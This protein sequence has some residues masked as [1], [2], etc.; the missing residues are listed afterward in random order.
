MFRD[1]MCMVGKA[2]D[3]TGLTEPAPSAFSGIPPKE[4]NYVN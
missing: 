2:A 1:R 4:K 3:R